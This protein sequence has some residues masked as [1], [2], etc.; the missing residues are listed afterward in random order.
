MKKI[1]LFLLSLV[2]SMISALI[3]LDIQQLIITP[4]T[5][6]GANHWVPE[7][8][9][10]IC[11]GYIVFTKLGKLTSIII[12]V[13]I[14]LYPILT[15]SLLNVSLALGRGTGSFFT[16]A[17]IMGMWLGSKKETKQ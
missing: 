8:L 7:F 6:F 9:L 4:L 10:L 1:I 13:C 2:V 15:Y 17:F 5:P 16:A 14:L 3:L 11:M 12:A